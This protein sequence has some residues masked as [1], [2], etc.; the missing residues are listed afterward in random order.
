MT[1]LQARLLFNHLSLLAE[2]RNTVDWHTSK[3]RVATN[4]RMP[5]MLALDILRVA[6]H[7]ANLPDLNR[8]LD[9]FVDECNRWT[10]ETEP[11]LQGDLRIADIVHTVLGDN[12]PDYG[13][14][15]LVAP[16]KVTPPGAGV[17]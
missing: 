3:V 15:G 5:Y 8:R 10:N 2:A 7:S 12:D 6:Q 16:V 4:P 14:V 17:G 11:G 13:F 1:N 9:L